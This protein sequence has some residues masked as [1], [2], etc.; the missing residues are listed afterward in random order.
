MP[1]PVN[2]KFSSF[3][4]GCVY[5]NV[6]FF[7]SYR[8]QNSSSVLDSTYAVV[9]DVEYSSPSHNI[10]KKKN[11]ISCLYNTPSHSTFEGVVAI[12]CA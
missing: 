11:D 3:L 1:C 10:T 6:E 7:A 5:P 2:S 12:Q 4:I 8:Y 9:Y